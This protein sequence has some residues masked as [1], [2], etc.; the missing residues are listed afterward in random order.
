M[1][2]RSILIRGGAATVTATLALAVAGQ[3]A[4]ATSVSQWTGVP[5]P[6]PSMSANRLRGLTA[7]DPDAV[8]AVGDWRDDASGQ[9]RTLTQHWDGAAWH[10]VDSADTTMAYNTLT[11]VAAVT[12]AELWAVGYA[13]DGADQ[14]DKGV[15]LLLRGDGT[16]WARQDV[17]VP[18]RFGALAAV[19]MLDGNDG[20]AVGS[21]TSD[22]G[23]DPQALI[24][25]WTG[26]AWR[27]VPAPDLGPRPA[28][29]T[30]VSGI[31]AD[32]VWA[33]GYTGGLDGDEQSVILHWDG[34]AWQQVKL[35]TDAG[36]RSS[37]LFGVAAGSAGEVWAVGYLRSTD[38]RQPYVLHRSGINWQE[39]AS[40]A[41]GDTQ[42]RSV[43]ALP[44]GV[45]AAGYRFTRGLDTALAMSFDGT[46]FVLEDL[47]LPPVS[48]G[49]VTGTAL[50]AIDATGRTGELW[51]VGCQSANT[52]VLRRLVRAL[53]TAPAAR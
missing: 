46:G 8:W 7:T 50:S 51:A 14:P 12:P 9:Q 2:K 45:W 34:N 44:A 16:S 49:N 37:A 53:S 30:G 31:R 43:V 25:R 24:L 41:P 19:D 28:H 23:A 47:P 17:E 26:G 11:A 40:G 15:P 1:I 48:T 6:N 38:E 20:W 5:S 4:E 36:N 52:Q 21:S 10:D 18:G 13:T 22:Q 42:L 35:G 33:V 27:V 39:V 3:A 29:L 32:D